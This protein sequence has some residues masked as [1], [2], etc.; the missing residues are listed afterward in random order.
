MA[1][2]SIIKAFDL[3]VRRIEFLAKFFNLTDTKINDFLIFLVYK[4]NWLLKVSNIF[5]F[6]F[7]PSYL[8][9]NLV[10]MKD[11]VSKRYYSNA[12]KFRGKRVLRTDGS[13]S[14][15]LDR[16]SEERSK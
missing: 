13:V 9:E 6:E 12:D 3:K 10:K 1:G 8:Y 14:F 15:F 16:L 2:L 11:N 5:I 4:Y 7:L